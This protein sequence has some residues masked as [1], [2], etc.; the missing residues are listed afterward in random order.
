MS[1][2]R[3]NHQL[4]LAFA[5][6]SRSEAPR[7]SGE[8]TESLGAQR[9]AESPAGIEPLMEA[10]CERSNC[11]QA[12]ARVKRNKGSAGIDGMTV[13]QLPAYLKQACSACSND[14]GQADL[15]CLTNL[16]PSP[17]KYSQQIIATF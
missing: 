7:D 9:E 13:E 14:P 1:D 2:Q 3:Q 5:E 6:M 11:K 10:V 17:A 15:N 4:V 8:G 16:L 12:L